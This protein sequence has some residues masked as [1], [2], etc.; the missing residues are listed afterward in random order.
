MRS[1]WL[2]INVSAYQQNLRQ[3]AAYTGVP[4]LAVVK[5]NAYGHGMERLARA[6]EHA[7]CPG[8]GVALPEEGAALRQAGQSGRMLVMGLALEE[9]ADLLVEHDLEAVVTR[10][11]MLKALTDAARRAGRPAAVHVKVDTGMTRVGVTPD[12][13]LPFCHAVAENPQLRLA[14]LLTHFAA[15]DELDPAFTQEQW[16]R[17]APLAREVDGWTTRPTLHAANS[18]A[19]L[20]YP[21]TRL[22]WVRAGL[23]TYGV[24]PGP[25]SL[26]IPMLPVASLH[27]KVVQVR[28][29]PAGSRVSY[30]G[31]WTAPRPSRLALLPVGYADGLPWALANQGS[32]L[33]HGWRAP[34][35]GRVCMDQVVVDVTDLPP[36]H[37]GHEAVL[38]GR[39]GDEEITIA[40]I[41]AQAR[42]IPYEVMTGFAARLPRVYV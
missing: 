4:V 7:G 13:A 29:V 2:Q 9:Q 16:E 28:E 20:W 14:G 18:A 34:I 11:H 21:E 31:T 22:D 1:A 25:H 41:A 32:V 36:V 15:A 10:P 38:I 35:R 24:N 8:V 6:A 39:Q 42:T 3:L 17:F 40:E 26:P 33:L 27:A 30:G 12:E 23:V 37:P 19:A 5:A